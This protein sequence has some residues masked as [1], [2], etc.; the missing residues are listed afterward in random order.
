MGRAQAPR[1]LAGVDEAGDRIFEQGELALK[2]RDVQILA[3]AALLPLVQGTQDADREIQARRKITDR[4]PHSNRGAIW[5]AGDAHQAGNGLDDAVHAG[6]GCPGAGLPEASARGV[7]QARVAGREC[8][9]AEPEPLGNARGGFSDDIGLVSQR[10]R[11]TPDRSGSSG[12][13]PVR[14]CR[15]GYW[16]REA[17]PVDEGGIGARARAQLHLAARP[18]R[19]KRQG[20]SGSSFQTGPASAQVKSRTLTPARA[21]VKKRCD[22]CSLET[23][24]RGSLAPCKIRSAARLEPTP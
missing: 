18:W 1:N 10:E 7:H 20:R 23:H 19:R 13:A 5:L 4:V 9:V 14:V 12:R 3:E 2:H 11:Q 6:P 8:L 22:Y 15:D 21:P 17:E 24:Y 16:R